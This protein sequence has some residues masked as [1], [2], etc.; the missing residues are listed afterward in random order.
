MDISLFGRNLLLAERKY[1]R[2]TPHIHVSSCNRSIFQVSE[3]ANCL[4]MMKELA[5]LAANVIVAWRER[6]VTGFVNPKA[7]KTKADEMIC[8]SQLE[9]LVDMMR[10]LPSK[11]VSSSVSF[12]SLCGIFPCII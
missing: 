11:G 10:N 12:V 3:V 9:L 6:L 1:F 5:P 4:K 7:T 8:N 2:I